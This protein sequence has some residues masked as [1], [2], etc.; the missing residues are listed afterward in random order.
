MASVKDILAHLNQIAPVAMAMDRDNVGHLVG[1]RDAE[2][3]R[4]LVA[5]DATETIIDEAIDLGAELIVAHHPVI[6]D[7]L[8]QV[9]DNDSTGRR[10]L[11]LARHDIAM[12]CM[13]TNLDI[14]AGGVNDV[15]A[16]ALGLSGT[17]ILWKMGELDGTAY[18][19]GR[20]GDL[21][22]PITMAD[23]LAQVKAAVGSA[24][25]RYY[26]AGRPVQR[27]AVLGGGGEDGLPMAVA[28]GCDAFVL[29]DARYHIFQE[30]QACGI[31]LIEADHYCT[32][33][34]IS[35]PLKES[36]STAFP[37]VEVTVSTRQGQVAKFF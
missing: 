21:P 27:V 16:E 37:G 7:S 11:K 10:V 17:E 25:L 29:G 9:T 23:F 18:G 13:H 33:N 14:A 6:F 35:E 4:V 32:E 2:V 12:I 8:R 30:A 22:A 26:D 24:G 36:I 1:R 5:L 20:V 34:L 19:L 31:S 3:T 15:L 28:A